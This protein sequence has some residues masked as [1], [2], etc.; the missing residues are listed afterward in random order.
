MPIRVLAARQHLRRKRPLSHSEE[1]L[2]GFLRKKEFPIMSTT[3]D[4]LRKAEEDKRTQETDAR[5]RL[6]SSSPRFD[7]RTPRRSHT[8]W[9]IGGG[10]VFLGIVCGAGLMLWRSSDT[11]PVVDAGL[12]PASASQVAASQSQTVIPPEPQPQNPSQ[13][14]P[15]A[16]HTQAQ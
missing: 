8:P 6:L 4:A 11:V 5:T 14:E 1:L 9:M 7:F 10:L 15:Q 16:S 13:S 2:R 3:L 12:P